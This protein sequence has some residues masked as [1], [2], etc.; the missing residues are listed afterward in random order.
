LHVQTFE[1]LRPYL[2]TSSKKI[3]KLDNSLRFILL[4]SPA[5]D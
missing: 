3:Y 5:Y 1:N 2:S 4:F